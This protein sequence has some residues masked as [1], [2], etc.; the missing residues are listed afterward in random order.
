MTKRAYAIRHVP[1]EDLGLLE[2]L[3][4]QRGYEVHMVDAPVADLCDPAL[5]TA[6][7]LILLG[8]PIGAYDEEL[9]PFLAA[10][11]ALAEKRLTAGQPILG[12]CLGAQIMALA[13]GAKVVPGPHKEIGFAPLTLTSEGAVSCLAPLAEDGGA[14]LHWHG[15]RFEVPKGAARLAF[16]DLTPNQAFSIGKHG[17]ALQFHGEARLASFE[18]WLVGHACELAGAGI[19]PAALRSDAARIFP[20]LEE[21]GLR[22]LGRWL[23]GLNG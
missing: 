7:L 23:D 14:V 4:Q 12:I 21:R 18:Y 5:D 6:D 10:E 9:Y 19:S 2:A 16:S 20:S 13:L 17:L 22:A 11:R 1:F 8:G 3:L 15:D